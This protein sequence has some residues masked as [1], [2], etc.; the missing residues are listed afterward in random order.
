MDIDTDTEMEMLSLF[1]LDN[2]RSVS[3]RADESDGPIKIYLSQVVA[4]ALGINVKTQ[5][6]TQFVDLDDETQSVDLD[7]ET[8]SVE[9]NSWWYDEEKYWIPLPAGNI[10]FD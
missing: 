6:E 5:E 4:K 8:Q 3:E 9:D 10:F 1:D 2:A 7:E